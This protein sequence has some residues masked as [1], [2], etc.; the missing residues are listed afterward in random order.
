M[1]QIPAS[2]GPLKGL[3]LGGGFHYNSK[4]TVGGTFDTSQLFVDSFVVFDALVG[5]QAKVFIRPVDFRLNA[6]KGAIGSE[7]TAV[8]Q[9]RMVSGGERRRG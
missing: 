5:C 6:K 9:R 3:I 8:P 2:S 1:G 7:V 4:G